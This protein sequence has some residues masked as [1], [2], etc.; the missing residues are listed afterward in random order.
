MGLYFLVPKHPINEGRQHT[1]GSEVNGRKPDQSEMKISKISSIAPES[2][3]TTGGAL[4]TT[5]ELQTELPACKIKQA[6][7]Y[8]HSGGRGQ[9]HF[10]SLNPLM[11]AFLSRSG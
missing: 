6:T 11:D 7:P 1:Q 10:A 5:R 8:K 4:L 2:Q 3:T 9:A